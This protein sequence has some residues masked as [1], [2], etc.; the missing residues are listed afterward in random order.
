MTMPSLY[1]ITRW[2]S[3][4]KMIWT[5]LQ[6]KDIVRYMCKSLDEECQSL[7]GQDLSDHQWDVIQVIHVIWV[8]IRLN[9]Y[10]P[11]LVGSCVSFRALS[12]CFKVHGR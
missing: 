2:Q 3:K 8:F 5:L 11:Y 12:V 9:I 1:V 6:N 4:Y 7:Q 10:L